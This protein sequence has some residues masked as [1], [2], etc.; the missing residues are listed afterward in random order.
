MEKGPHKNFLKVT[1]RLS[2]EVIGKIAVENSMSFEGVKIPS[3]PNYY[4]PSGVNNIKGEP[5][6]TYIDN[7][8]QW[9][10]YCYRKKFNT[11][12]CKNYVRHALPT[13]A[14]P[15]PANKEGKRKCAVFL[16]YPIL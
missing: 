4:V 5:Y 1:A 6:F 13:G 12:G 11:K 7:P 16:H 14:R 15:V 2:M 10:R 3:T 9:S 8:G